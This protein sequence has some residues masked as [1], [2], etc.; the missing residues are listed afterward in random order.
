M[1]ICYVCSEYPPGPHG[2][3]GTLVQTLARGLVRAGHDVSVAGYY[4]RSYP[5]PDIQND[6][7]VMIHRFRESTRSLGWVRNRWTLYRTIARWAR[8]GAIDLVE[9]PDWEGWA[10]GWQKLPV[11]V[12]VRL[13]GTAGYFASEMGRRVRRNTFLLENA[14]LRRA[15][16]WCSESKYMASKTRELYGLKKDPD[17]IIYNPVEVPPHERPFDQRSRTKVMFA[18]TLTRKKGIFSI[19]RAWPRVI[20]ARPDAELHIWGKDTQTD[21]GASTRALVTSQLDESTRATVFFHG[22]VALEELL[23]EFTRARVA[24]FPSYAEGFALVPMHAMAAGCPTVYT[25]RGSGPE[26]I[27][28]EKNGLLVDPDRPEEIADA[29][30]RLLQDD[31][32]AQ[33]LGQL[34]RNHIKRSFSLET[35]VKT[36]VEFYQDCL[37]RF[38]GRQWRVLEGGRRSHSPE[39]EVSQ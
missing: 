37:E 9:V 18:G 33:R 2:G 14:S 21:D 8:E 7:G 23:E 31:T 28:S 34:G 22:H 20:A 17:A 38:H 30:V 15:D 39:R 13:S 16:F 6:C 29:V 27:E 1:R 11:P 36:N 32:V 12:I 26:L 19:I 3:V 35:A 5:A 10:A 24:L 4:G 25:A